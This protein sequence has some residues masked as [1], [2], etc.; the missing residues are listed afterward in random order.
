[1]STL[2]QIS[3]Q[4]PFRA[5]F[6]APYYAALARDAYAAEGVAVTLLPGDAPMH[7][8]DSITDGRAHLAWGGPMRILLAHD[9]D[10]ACP[11]RNFGAAIL[12]DP[13][14]LVGRD[15]RPGFTLRDLAGLTLGTVAEVPTPWWTLQE[16]IRQAGL[17]PTTLQRVTDRGMGENAQ[18]VS[19]GRLDVAQ[20]FEPLVSQM[21]M[22]GTGHVWHECA[23]RGPTSYTTFYSTTA[24]IADY[25]PEFMAMI[26]A[27]AATQRW[28]HAAEPTEI[29]E[30]IAPFFPGLDRALMARSIARYLRLGIWTTTPH[31]P[32]EPFERLQRHMLTA[33]AIRREPGYAHCVDDDITRRALD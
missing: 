10:P 33:G 17:D 1:M 28:F 20:L 12:G 9:K 19:E 23:A 27:L 2:R 31:F 3:L 30:T 15:P 6:Y 4:E 5:L 8:T 26:R 29:A 14:L 25:A 32:P 11:L 22:A 13:F 7:A 16:D 21:E 18:A 24:N